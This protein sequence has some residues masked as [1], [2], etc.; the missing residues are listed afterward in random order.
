MTF[1]R[2]QRSGGQVER[3]NRK[4]G[5]SHTTPKAERSLNWITAE[6]NSGPSKYALLSQ[7]N[8]PV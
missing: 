6:S 4:Q 3:S 7:I 2:E 1:K 8:I 5:A